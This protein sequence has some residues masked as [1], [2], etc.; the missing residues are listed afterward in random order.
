VEHTVTSEPLEIRVERDGSHTVVRVPGDRAVIGRG[1]EC[2]VRLEDPLASRSHCRIERLGPEVFVVDLGSAN[3]TWVDGLRVERR[4]IGAYA[5]VRVG[6]TMLRLVGSLADRLAAAES[7][8]TQQ[9]TREREMLELVL[10]VARALEAEE[11]V[12]RLAALLIDAGISL[13]RAERGFV[14][15][16]QEGRT[17]LAVGRNF[18]G[19]PVATPETKVSR[20]LLQRALASTKPLLLQD[21]ASDSEF[22]GVESISDLGLRSLLAVPLRG[23]GRV[24]G[25]LLVDHRL[26]SGA[27]REEDVN[28]L[29]G[30]AALAGLHLAAAEDRRALTS[31]HRRI[32][33][34][35]RELGKR[36][37]DRAAAR[38][39]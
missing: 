3:G 23:G 38:P 8:Q 4:A 36:V 17:S 30:L 37:Q 12:E 24:L 26:A 32:T 7:T 21:A 9:H 22:A 27:F 11:R 20:T 16:I 31:A 29:A 19:E 28:L 39:D 6:S 15:L 35:Q 18:A 1:A 13:T 34:L 5:S 14:F 25:L 2:D 33:T 10:T